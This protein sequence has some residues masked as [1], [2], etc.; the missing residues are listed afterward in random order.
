[1]NERNQDFIDY[2]ATEECKEALERDGISIHVPSGDM[3][4][5]NENTG[6]FLFHLF[7]KYQEDRGRPKYPIRHSTLTDDNCALSALQDRSWPYFIN[8]IIEFSQGFINLSDMQDSDPTGVN[9][10]N[11]TRANFEIVKAVYNELLVSV[12]INLYEFF[13][14]VGYLVKQRIDT[15]LTNNNYFPWNPNE[16]FI[17]NRILTTYRD[18]YYE[19]GRFP[20]RS[21]LIPVSRARISEFIRFQDVLSPRSLYESYVGRDMQGVVSLQLLA[22]FNR[23]LGGDTAVSR[24]AMSELFHNLSWQVLTNDNNSIQV[25]LEAVTTLI[26]RINRLLQREVYEAKKEQIKRGKEIVDKLTS[27]SK[28]D[29]KTEIEKIEEKLEGELAKNERDF[30]IIED[31]EAKNKHDL[32]KSAT[33]PGDGIYTN[34]EITH[35]DYTKTEHNETAAPQLDPSVLNGIGIFLHG[36]NQRISEDDPDNSLPE[37]EYI[38]EAKY[39]EP[40]EIKPNLQHILTETNETNE[41]YI[42]DIKNIKDEIKTEFEEIFVEIEPSNQVEDPLMQDFPE[43][44][45]DGNL[46]IQ[47]LS[48]NIFQR[49]EAIKI[50]LI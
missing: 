22:A 39:Q 7:N 9:I 38:S 6:E 49:L 13:K 34:E 46:T 30:E 44:F 5:D 48:N 18:F 10:L 2:L 40:E 26:Q 3:Y 47:N 15:D 11:N 16:D 43:I 8:R 27:K 21:T 24:D 50:E 33:D 23:F 41:E 4:I 25:Q 36:I 31:I 19:T 42:E 17:Q 20:G 12:G 35:L 29:N 45:E 28:E 1:M 32:I 37:L 14:I